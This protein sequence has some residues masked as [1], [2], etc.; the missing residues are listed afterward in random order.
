M[1]SL[2]EPLLASFSQIRDEISLYSWS[3]QN[4]WRWQEKEYFSLCALE[5]VWN[6]PLFTKFSHF[7]FKHCCCISIIT[8]SRI[9]TRPSTTNNL[10]KYYLLNSAV[11]FDFT[12]TLF[13]YPRDFKRENLHTKKLLT[14]E[15]FWECL[16]SSQEELFILTG[17]R[18]T[19]Y[20]RYWALSESLRQAK[21]REIGREWGEGR[22]GRRKKSFPAWVRWGWFNFK[23]ERNFVESVCESNFTLNQLH[24]TPD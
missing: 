22:G 8:N 13:N 4:S 1:Q 3:Y 6:L 11:Q 12:V 5:Q 24:L 19:T 2:P 18:D 23:A 10:R 17:N 15:W 16:V 7:S 14:K 20:A 21:Q 9:A